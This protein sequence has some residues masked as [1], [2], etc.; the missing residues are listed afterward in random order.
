MKTPKTC[1]NCGSEDLEWFCNPT[2]LGG[3]VDGKLCM[4]EIGVSF[5][6]GCNHCSET[7]F[8]VG[9]DRI[10]EYLNSLRIENHGN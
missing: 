9:G 2:N 3:V 1:K 4:R 10:A 6:L 8:V 5:F 7:L